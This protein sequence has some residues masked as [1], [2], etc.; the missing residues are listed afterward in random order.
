M[1]RL[2]L[3]SL[4]I[5]TLPLVVKKILF[6]VIEVVRVIA[7]L[8]NFR[9][10]CVC[11][12]LSSCSQCIS[13]HSWC[14]SLHLGWP[15]WLGHSWLFWG[16][17]DTGFSF[18]LFVSNWDWLS[19]WPNRDGLLSDGWQIVHY[20]A[21]MI[22]SVIFTD[23]AHFSCKEMFVGLEGRCD[24]LVAVR[25]YCDGTIASTGVRVERRFRSCVHIGHCQRGVHRRDGT[26]NA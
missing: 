2:G 10:W 11:L 19:R 20:G 14:F 25:F 24:I 5:A 22:S 8:L 13:S 3:V 1:K 6:G 26:H 23:F 15:H 21:K 9:N 12:C 16:R 7:L 18:G 17:W 4:L